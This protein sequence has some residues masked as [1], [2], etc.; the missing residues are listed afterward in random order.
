MAALPQASLLQF[1][2]PPRCPLA[3]VPRIRPCPVLGRRSRHSTHSNKDVKSTVTISTDN[4]SSTSNGTT[5]TDASQQ[6][7]H[8]DCIGTGM[9]VQC[10][11]SDGDDGTSSNRSAQQSSPLSPL[12]VTDADVHQGQ[13]VEVVETGIGASSYVVED[14]QAAQPPQQQQQQQQQAVQAP[15][16]AAAA[17]ASGNPL[18]QL[19]GVALL[20][21]PFFFWGTSM[22]AMKV[23]WFHSLLVEV[24]SGPQHLGTHTVVQA[25]A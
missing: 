24:I 25:H 3:A 14:K 4:A 23:G 19:L 1:A 15:A 13:H 21:S 9:D 5:S 22:V 16:T 11:I 12:G 18:Q 10:Y 17:A 7:P 2:R 20:I 6:E 8:I